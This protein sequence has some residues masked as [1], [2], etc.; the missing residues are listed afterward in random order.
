MGDNGIITNAMSAKQKQGMAALEEYLQQKYV[1]YF[2]D[3]DQYVNKVELL[4]NKLTD[5]LLTNSTSRKYIIY[6]GKTHYLLNKKSLPQE[7]QDGLIGGD[8][9]KTEDFSKLIDVY[10]I[11]TDLKVYYVNT[12]DGT[13]Y[14]NMNVE[15]VNPDLYMPKV[16]SDSAMNEVIREALKEAGVEIDETKGI[17]IDN[18]SKI[19]KLT[20]DGTKNK[21]TNIEALSELLNLQELTLKNLT[22]DNLTGIETLGMLNYIYFDNCKISDYSKMANVL[23]LKY[24]Y[25][26]F[27]TT[28]TEIEANAQITNLGNGMANATRIDGLEYLY[29]FGDNTNIIYSRNNY[30]WD[31]TDDGFFKYSSDALSNLTDISNLKK[32]PNNIKNSVI[33][34]YLNNHKITDISCLSDFTG[35]QNVIMP[36][37]PE[38]H[39]LKGLENKENLLYLAAQQPDLK[40]ATGKTRSDMG[41]S[42]LDGLKGCS[43]LLYLVL[44]NNTNLQ[45]ISG[46]KD[47]SSLIRLYANNCNITSTDGLQG[48]DG[49]GL[50]SLV[51]LNLEN[52]VNLESVFHINECD[53]IVELYLAG[54]IN[55]NDIEAIALESVIL[56]CG[57]NY[58]IPQKYSLGFSSVTSLDFSNSDFTDNDLN[59]LRNRTNIIRLKLNGCKSLTNKKINEILPTMTKLKYLDLFG[60]SNLTSISFVSNLRLV[61]LNIRYTGVKDLS[62]LNNESSA[63]LTAFE[64]GNDLINDYPEL[65]RNVCNNAGKVLYL[66]KSGN[67][68]IAKTQIDEPLESGRGLWEYVGLMNDSNN[69]VIKVPEDVSGFS[70]CWSGGNNNTFDL[71]ECNN[72][73]YLYLGSW[74]GSL[75]FPSSLEA[76]VIEAHRPLNI[77]FSLSAKLSYYLSKGSWT[78]DGLADSMGSL[79]DNNV[80][81]FLELDRGS[82]VSLSFLSSFDCTSLRTLIMIGSYY[83]NQQFLN[84]ISL[85]GVENAYELNYLQIEKTGLCDLTG[86]D[87][88][89]KLT[90]LDLANN[91]LDYSSQVSKIAECTNI[92]TLNLD[93]NKIAEISFL[94][95]LTALTTA[96]LSNNSFSQIPDLSNL[97]SLATLNIS[98]CTNITDLRPLESLIRNG[99]T[100]LRTLNLQNCTGIESVSST[101]GY[102]NKSLIDRLKNAGCNSI[103][104]TGTRL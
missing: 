84:F 30:G 83:V 54:N 64:F 31:R 98:G 77:D 11:T 66:E 63:N 33:E 67:S 44:F 41:Y 51:Y 75:I 73:K 9:D 18:V 71:S 104:T 32:L 46:I 93:N 81:S 8:S 95:S 27:P 89:K 62:P 78:S 47:S 72:L 52:N 2:E 103:T 1:E 45:N 57:S 58:S 69:V 36:C 99:T 97:T 90:N 10:G 37:N 92:T 24:L 7:I 87:S 53:K 76:L 55:M 42:N 13:Q 34:L 65:I 96:N 26:Y 43:K 68:Y 70:C 5:L 38:L 82:I 4:S 23:K 85:S 39:S 21:V 61:K 19:S 100:P 14:G 60:I 80:L 49:N 79:P 17:T 15:D 48:K 25:F 88:L 35:L 12:L 102:D 22:L 101:T 28:M 59:N 56:K 91:K 20:I 3:T 29:I 94:S 6:E 16:N 50:D 74:S 86:L 40:D